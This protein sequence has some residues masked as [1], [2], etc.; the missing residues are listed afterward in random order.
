M[1]SNDE[2]YCHDNIL[3]EMEIE[4]GAPLVIDKEKGTIDSDGELWY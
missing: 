2:Y 3:M 4:N 1:P